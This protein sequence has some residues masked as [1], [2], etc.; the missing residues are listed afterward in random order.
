[1]ESLALLV[2]IL[3]SPAMFGGPLALLLA[4]WRIDQIS[5]ARRILIYFLS[6]LSLISGALILYQNVSR[7][8][9]VV[10]LIGIISA[11]IALVRVRS[12]SSHRK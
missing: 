4:L 12:N 6:F 2:T 10:G 11:V 3:I 7:G 1:M 9:L 5:S 8:G